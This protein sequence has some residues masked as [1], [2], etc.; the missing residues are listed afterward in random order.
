MRETLVVSGRG[1]ITPPAALRKRFGIQSYTA[2]RWRDCGLLRLRVRDVGQGI[3]VA[4]PTAD[5]NRKGK[6]T[7]LALIHLDPLWAVIG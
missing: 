2:S 7:G 5:Q 1:Q 6:E 3:G 4:E